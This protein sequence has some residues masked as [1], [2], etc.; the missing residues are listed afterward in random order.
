LFSGQWLAGTITSIAF[1]SD[2]IETCSF[3]RDVSL[4]EPD[5]Y[6]QK[7]H[8]NDDGSVDINFLCFR[9]CGG[10]WNGRSIWRPRGPCKM[11]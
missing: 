4:V 5:S 3:I 6:D 1:A 2:R 8:D 10:T 11:M 7:M 9:N